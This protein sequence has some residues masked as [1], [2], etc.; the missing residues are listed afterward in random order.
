[1]INPLFSINIY[2]TKFNNIKKLKSICEFDIQSESFSS[3][4]ASYKDLFNEPSKVSSNLHSWRDNSGTE[5]LHTTEPF[6][7]ITQFIESHAKI[8]WDH[9]EYYNDVRPKIYQSWITKYHHGGFIDKHDHLPA[10][11]TGVL[12]LNASP[13]QG[14]LVFENPLELWL[15]TQPYSADKRKGS[16]FQQEIPVATGDLI[17]FPGYLRHYTLPNRSQQDRI[18]M[19]FNLNS[20]GQFD[21]PY[22][23]KI[24]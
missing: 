2:K 24:L 17:L 12:Y 7:E 14:N 4:R 13:E 10:S 6:S 16:F 5:K 23:K 22:R 9:I 1:M 19:S 11:L 18:I 21:N 8:Y 15:R 20:T 3:D